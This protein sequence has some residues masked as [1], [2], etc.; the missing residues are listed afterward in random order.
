MNQIIGQSKKRATGKLKVN[1]GARYAA[2]IP[3]KNLTHA[4]LTTSTIARG[5]ITNIDTREAQK[6]PGIIAIITYQNAPKLPFEK[7]PQTPWVN[8]GEIGE[9]PHTLHTDRIYFYGYKFL[10]S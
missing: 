10:N 3:I 6:L 1:G 5:R 9:Y 7:V 4:F 2:E 8:P